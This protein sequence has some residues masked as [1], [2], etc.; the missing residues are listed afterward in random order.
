MFPV[1]GSREI[2][3][4]LDS[5]DIAARPSASRYLVELDRWVSNKG[6]RGSLTGALHWLQNADV[7]LA[8]INPLW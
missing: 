6:L 4:C 1:N 7:V 2:H 3:L 5:V 8:D